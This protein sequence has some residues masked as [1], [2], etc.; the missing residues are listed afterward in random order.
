MLKVVLE[1]TKIRDFSEWRIKHAELATTL[2]L[3]A[4]VDA[5]DEPFVLELI[6]ALES[7]STV[8]LY[9]GTAQ[10]EYAE[11]A[12]YLIHVDGSTLA[13]IEDRLFTSPWGFFLFSKENLEGVRRHLRR[14][15]MVK[16]P[17]NQKMYFRF[18]DP[19]VLEDYLAS[20]AH[21][22]L[23]EFFGQASVLGTMSCDGGCLYRCVEER[24]P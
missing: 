10:T 2:K 19:R 1:K 16:G 15:L 22:E 8:S 13:L 4:V 14:Y 24:I 6:A 21:L 11:I 18:Y 5:C 12:P 7:L 9:S 23:Q 17:D 20:C 3:Y